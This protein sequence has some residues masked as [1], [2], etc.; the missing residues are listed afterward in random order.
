MRKSVLVM[1]LISILI[2]FSVQFPIVYGGKWVSKYEILP[3]DAFVSELEEWVEVGVTPWLDKDDNE[4]AYIYIDHSDDDHKYFTFQNLQNI[5]EIESVFLYIKLWDEI[6]YQ[7]ITIITW[8]PTDPGNYTWGGGDWQISIPASVWA[9]KSKN[10]TDRWN[11]IAGVNNSRIWFDGMSS[12]MMRNV[13]YA[14]LNVTGGFWKS[15]PFV[16]PVRIILG[17]IG[18]AIMIIS[19]AIGVRE[20]YKN[21]NWE[22]IGGCITL[23]AIGYALVICW[24]LP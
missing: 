13:T 7:P 15:T 8:F 9:L 18:V 11:T 10:Y 16:Y 17:L 6:G 22:M 14:Y 21:K 24:L 12:N 23:F 1:V 2:G 4:T 3:V 19:P 20:V 5:T